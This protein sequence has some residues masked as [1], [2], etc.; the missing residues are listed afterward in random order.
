MTKE[1]GVKYTE[2]GDG[3]LFLVQPLVDNPEIIRRQSRG[4]VLPSIVRCWPEQRAGEV[5]SRLNPPGSRPGT[6]PIFL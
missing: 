5:L 6:F 2:S 3:P 1:F 4:F